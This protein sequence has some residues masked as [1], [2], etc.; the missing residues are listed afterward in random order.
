MKISKTW[1]QKYYQCP[2]CGEDHQTETEEGDIE[3]CLSCG[4]EFEVGKVDN[5]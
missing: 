1:L 3:K 5:E 2:Y 4:K